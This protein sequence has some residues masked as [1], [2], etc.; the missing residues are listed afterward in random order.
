MDWREQ[1]MLVDQEGDAC[2][3]FRSS[4]LSVANLLSTLSQSPPDC[5]AASSDELAAALSLASELVLTAAHMPHVRQSAL[6]FSES[7]DEMSVRACFEQYKNA[8]VAGDGEA[9]ASCVDSATLS[10]YADMSAHAIS[11]KREQLLLLPLVDQLTILVIRTKLDAESLVAMNGRELFVKAVSAGWT[12]KNS[13]QALDL[14]NI[15]VDGNHAE[16]E[17]LSQGRLLPVMQEFVRE[18]GVW[19]YRL[20]ATFPAVDTALRQLAAANGISNEE[21]VLAMIESNLGAPPS[22]A[23]WDPLI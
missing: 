21:L 10:H 1:I 20:L 18:D 19:K 13:I 11:S 12:G 4:K 8:A 17:A 14:G 15:A 6:R 22:A 23:I 3:V 5:A 2:L 9:A 16:A 7:G